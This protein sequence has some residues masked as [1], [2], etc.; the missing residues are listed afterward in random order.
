MRH[1][2]GAAGQKTNKITYMFALRFGAGSELNTHA[3][4]GV[5][6]SHQAFCLHFHTSRLQAQDN[7]RALREWRFRFYIAPTQAEVAQPAF[8]DGLGIF[9]KKFRRVGSDPGS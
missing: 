2:A 5:H 1:C 3:E 6:D 7:A 4:F 9:G 8:R